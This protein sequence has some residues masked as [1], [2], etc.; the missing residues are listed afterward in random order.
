MCVCGCSF[1]ARCTICPLLAGVKNHRQGAL[2]L[3]WLLAPPSGLQ[4][5]LWRDTV[6][7]GGRHRYNSEQSSQAGRH[8]A[9]GKPLSNAFDGFESNVRHQ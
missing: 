8:A 7:G 5:S 3:E 2:K 1:G 9:A 4:Q 6:C